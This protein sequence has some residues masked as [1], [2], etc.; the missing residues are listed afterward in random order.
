[1]AEPGDALLDVW[2]VYEAQQDRVHQEV[3]AAAL[4][5]PELAPVV[6]RAQVS[7]LAQ[8]ISSFREL[9]GRAIREGAWEPWLRYASIAFLQ[10]PLT[11]EVLVR[12]VREVLD[13]PPPA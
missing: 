8:K 2:N 9:V 10:K 5:H 7:Q 13:G 4:A 1:M 6:Q 3:L 12:K 11:P